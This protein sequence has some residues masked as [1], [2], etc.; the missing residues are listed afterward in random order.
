MKDTRKKITK[1][2]IEL[3]KKNGY[4]NTSVADICKASGITKGTFYYHFPNKDEISFEFYKEIFY[5]FNSAFVD[6]FMIPNAREQL[7]KVFEFTIDRTIELTPSVLQA[8][9]LS[10]LKKGFDLFSPFMGMSKNDP[11]SK[12]RKLLYNIVIKG[13]QSGQIR[14]GDPEIMLRAYTA[15]IIGI[16]LAWGC[17]NGVFDE[18]EELKKVFDTIF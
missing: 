10:D 15:A 3:Y 4:E 13:Q 8:I 12:M 16:A 7:W 14:E 2:A 1:C 9:I 5:D 18:K 11:N 6:I 17:E